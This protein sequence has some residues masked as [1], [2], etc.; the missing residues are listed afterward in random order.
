MQWFKNLR[1]SFK[2]AIAISI[3][4][5]F[6]GIIGLTGYSG[7]R[8]IEND[9]N[10]MFTV[11]LPAIDALIE[12]DR[13]LQQ[14]LV[15]E[16]SLIFAK[17][18]DETFNELV[19]EYEKNLEQAE[20]RV[21]KYAGLASSP[22]EL[23][24]I[25]QYK[26]AKDEWLA[27][28]KQV[29]EGRKADTR[30]GRRLALDLTLG[31]AKEKFEYMRDFLDQLTELNLKK[32]EENHK[33]ANESY[34]NTVMFI[35]TV[36]LAGILVGGI[37]TWFVAQSIVRPVSNTVAGLKD[38][39]EGEGDL[40]KRL[41]ATNK[42]ELGEL[43]YWFNTFLAKLQNI[44]G[45]IKQKAANLDQSSTQMT[46]LSTQ[47]SEDSESMSGRSN[48]LAAAAEQMSNNISSV[49]SNMEQATSNTGM[50]AAA[51]EEMTSTVNEIARN[52]EGARSVTAEAVT[53]AAS[54][55]EKVNSL[56]QA[57]QAINKV[58]EVITEISEQTNLLALNATI[59]A[60]RAG[61]AGKGFA[62][63]ANEIKELAKQTAQATQEIRNQIG[64][65][66]N[67]T[68]DTVS[69]I[70]LITK[71]INDV[72]E[73]VST[74]ATAVEEQSATTKEIAANISQASAG[75]QETNHNLSQSTEATRAIANEIAEVSTSAGNF[76]GSSS[77][78]NL[79]AQ[80]LSTLAT[81]LNELV[82]G[83]QV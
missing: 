82:N 7:A 3:V 65:I 38:I 13:D 11:Q 51:T 72:N 26:N 39:A 18:G 68:A 58:T 32:A 50:V 74:I 10:Q 48:T 36:S 46:S 41:D 59:E 15:A 8:N 64:S 45:D 17:T 40:T 66:Q 56:G 60:A 63:V 43:A 37:I 1:I 70:G 28:S 62:V 27:V 6:M 47:M 23:K 75:L 67:S 12:A 21:N 73:I 53:R 20:E 81:E 80:E 42:D 71:V 22:E 61:E 33:T 49:S 29:V 78:V 54:A 5:I 44:I 57:A 69:E 2:L 76:S 9:L 4:I 16:R 30:Q 25:S 14:L 77:Q 24:L 31:P 83:F 52:S 34:R 55:S 35:I 79:S 19:D